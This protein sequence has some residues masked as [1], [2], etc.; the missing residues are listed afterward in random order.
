MTDVFGSI[1]KTISAGL[2]NLLAIAY[3]QTCPPGYGKVFAGCQL[4]GPGFYSNGGYHSC[5]P[6]PGVSHSGKEARTDANRYFLRSLLS[7][8]SYYKQYR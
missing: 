4:C 1:R 3:A 2:F 6:C 5:L 8:S 7:A